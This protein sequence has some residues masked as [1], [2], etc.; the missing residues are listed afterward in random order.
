MTSEIISVHSGCRYQRQL[1]SANWLVITSSAN[2]F[3][4]RSNLPQNR[5]SPANEKIR[6]DVRKINKTVGKRQDMIKNKETQ[7]N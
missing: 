3:P 6:R 7:V 2:R 1:H 4:T 5:T